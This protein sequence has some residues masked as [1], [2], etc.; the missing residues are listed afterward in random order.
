MSTVRI[1]KG[2]FDRLSTCA[3]ARGIIAAAA[4]DQRG[5]LQKA[6]AKQRGEGGTASADDLAEFKGLV[7]RVLTRHA[8]AILM[9]PEYGLGALEERA[10]GTGALL[11]YE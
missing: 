9:D 5:S 4:M 7:T 11:A 2:K 8:S 3:D 10:P 6:I 1:T